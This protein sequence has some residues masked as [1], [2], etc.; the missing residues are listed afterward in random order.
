MTPLQLTRLRDDIREWL[1]ENAFGNA[2][3]K[4]RRLLVAHLEWLG[5]PL[6]KADPDRCVRKAYEDLAVVGSCQRGLFYIATAEDRRIAS[7]GLHGKA[8]AVLAREKMIKAAPVQAAQG[9]LW[10]GEA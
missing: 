3:A 7:G 6:P 4:P 9:N 5:H 10:G 1:R 2:N 8:L